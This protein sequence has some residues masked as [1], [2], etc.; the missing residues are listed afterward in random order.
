[1]TYT[2]GLMPLAFVCAQEALG[3][4]KNRGKI[5]TKNTK[6]IDDTN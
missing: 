2:Q 4:T 5:E 1:M 3:D 6:G